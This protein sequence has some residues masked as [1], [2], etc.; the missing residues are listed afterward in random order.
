MSHDSLLDDLEAFENEIETLAKDVKLEDVLGKDTIS[1]PPAPTAPQPSTASATVSTNAPARTSILLP[2]APSGMMRPVM[3]RPPV[4]RTIAVVS[5]PPTAAT[6]SS[7]QAISTFNSV[8]R[9]SMPGVVSAAPSGPSPGTPV[10]LTASS[11]YRASEGTFQGS[12]SDSKTYAGPVA[13]PIA[14]NVSSSAAS[15]T[16]SGDAAGPQDKRPNLR[17]V[18][19][20]V[21]EDKTLDDWPENDYRMFVG[22]LGNEVTDAILTKTFSVYP[23]FAM[24]RVVREKHGKHKSK[25]YGFVSFMNPLEMARA[26]REMDGKYCGD[27]KMTIKRY[28]KK[29]REYDPRKHKKQR[30]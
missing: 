22:N 30:R 8:S 11:S 27:R 7:S 6:P 21:W 13:G 20:K 3:S 24:A 18:A 28:D 19:G 26:F 5:R 10:K 9:S 29:E 1:H 12:A 15:A 2:K 25:G 16:A 4:P 17:C 14:P 23:S